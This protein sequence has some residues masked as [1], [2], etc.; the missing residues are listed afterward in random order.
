SPWRWLRS[1]G[2]YAVLAVLVIITVFPI[3]WMVVTAIR[4]ADANLIYPPSL[5]PQSLDLSPVKRLFQDG[6]IGRWILNSTLL[7]ALVTAICVVLAVFGAYVISMMR[8]RGRAAFA[9]FL[10]MT[11]M[12][13]EAL[14][15]VPIYKIFT[16]LGLRES[17][18]GLSLIDAAFVL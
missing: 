15:I 9:I 7:S 1:A 12:L 8:W 17:L 4:P 18:F 16:D 5:W 6:D 2:Y 13:P 14:I 10:L 11:Q 3:Y